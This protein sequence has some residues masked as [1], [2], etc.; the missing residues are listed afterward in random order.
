MNIKNL[1]WLDTNDIDL[2]NSTKIILFIVQ[3]SK[4]EL[5]PNLNTFKTN[6]VSSSLTLLKWVK[7]KLR[8]VWVQFGSNL[9][10][11]EWT[12]Q[13]VKFFLFL[14]FEGEKYHLQK[15]E[16]RDQNRV[17]RTFV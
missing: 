11:I 4:L 15:A 1:I 12:K 13:K 14:K 7:L 3:S 16:G 8:Q 9:T 17:F 10:L 6:S 2:T 5:E